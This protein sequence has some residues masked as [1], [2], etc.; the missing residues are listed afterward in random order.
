MALMHWIKPKKVIFDAYTSNAAIY[1]LAKITRSTREKPEWWNKLPKAS[2]SPESGLAH[3]M[4]GCNGFNDLYAKGFTVKSPCDFYIKKDQ[5]GLSVWSAAE[6]NLGGEHGLDQ[7][8]GN[9][10]GGSSFHFKL[11]PQWVLHSN[12]SID[13]L[14]TNHSWNVP[15]SISNVFVPNGV[16]NYNILTDVNVNMILTPNQVGQPLSFDALQPVAMLIPLTEKSVEIK[17]HLITPEELKDKK[18]ADPKQLFFVNRLTKIKKEKA[19]QA[20]TKGCPFGFGKN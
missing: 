6:F 11:N 15:Q 2:H 4:R 5:D 19:K 16:V 12:S 3:T 18:D 13:F 8:G 17:H 20:A 7:M 14:M 10:F 9:V 1:D